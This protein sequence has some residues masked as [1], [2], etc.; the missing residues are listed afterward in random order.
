MRVAHRKKIKISDGFVAYLLVI[1]GGNMQLFVP[2]AAGL[3][4]PVKRQLK[5]LGYGD[6]PAQNGRISVEGDWQDVARLNVFLRAGER[7]LL[8]IKTF[9]ATTFDELFEGAKTAPWE[10]FFTPHTKILLDGKSYKS[11]LMAVKAAGGVVKKAILTRLK[12]RLG[13]RAFDEKGERAVVGVSIVQDAVT[14]TLDTS[15]EG[16][17]KRGYRVL[18]YDAPLRETMAAALIDTSFFHPEKPL[19]DLFCGSGTIPIEAALIA[20]GIAPNENR[21]FDF[22]RWKCVPSVLHLAKEEAKDYHRNVKPNIFAG[23]I[24]PRAI[25]IAKEHARRA[26]VL[27]CITFQTQDMRRFTSEEK[28]GVLLSNPP[29][30]ER[31]SGTETELFPLYRD[32]SRTFRALKDW[33]CYLVTSYTGVERAF[34]KRADKTRTLFNANLECRFYSYLGKKPPKEEND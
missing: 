14:L 16:L 29:Y 21:S 22:T 2:V 4:A 18:T 15:G 24:S 27:D 8:H 32:F 33:S 11:K 5:R 10:E 17:H 1:G 9:S 12:E 34:G 25:S 26:G 7:V 31:L 13:A 3:E 28:Y 20:R 23:D 6:C 19:A 30:G